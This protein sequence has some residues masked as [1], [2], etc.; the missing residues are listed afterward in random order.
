MCCNIL[1]YQIN[2]VEGRVNLTDDDDNDND[3]DYVLVCGH[4][5]LIIFRG[6]KNC[7]NIPIK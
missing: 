1:Y 7:I 3:N 5:L 2:R 4:Y 6:R